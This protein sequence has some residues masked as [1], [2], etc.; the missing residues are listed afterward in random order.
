MRI[1]I[2]LFLLYFVAIFLNINA[3]VF[4]AV[5][6]ICKHDY[7]LK[8]LYGT[9]RHAQCMPSWFFIATALRP[10]LSRTVTST[11]SHWVVRMMPGA[12]N[13]NRH[14][15]VDLQVK[16]KF[17]A[18]ADFSILAFIWSVT[19]LCNLLLTWIWL[20]CTFVL[21]CTWYEIVVRYAVVSHYAT[22]IEYQGNSLQ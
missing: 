7:R 6:V 16:F 2:S 19:V 14:C 22:V 9:L 18:S 5:V 11:S 13:V 17:Q 15:V 8:W 4:V 21:Y 12:S 3:Y 20:L 10:C 1:K